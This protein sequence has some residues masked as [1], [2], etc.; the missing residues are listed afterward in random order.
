MNNV[1]VIFGLGFS[2]EEIKK[3]LQEEGYTHNF[4]FGYGKDLDVKRKAMK[5]ASECWIFGKVENTEDY[6]L[7]LE[8]GVDLWI[9]G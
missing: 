9:M 6:K 1:Y 5:I 8:Y 2:L 4:F 7:A 3:D